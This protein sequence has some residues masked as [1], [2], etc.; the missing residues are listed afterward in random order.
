M[1]STNA[2]GASAANAA[3][4]RWTCTRSTPC[5]A[6]SSSFSRTFVMVRQ[7]ASTRIEVIQNL[8]ALVRQLERGEKR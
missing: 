4:K 1:R 5:A 7:N 8:P 6:S 3:E 2:S